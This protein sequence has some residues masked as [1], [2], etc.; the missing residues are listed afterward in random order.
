MILLPTESSN[1]QQIFRLEFRSIM[2]FIKIFI[3][4]IPEIMDYIKIKENHITRIDGYLP[5]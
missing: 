1:I 3:L 4:L 5:G 2:K